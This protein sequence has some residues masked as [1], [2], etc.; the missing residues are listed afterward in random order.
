MKRSCDED[1]QF[2]KRA[3]DV[4]SL[5][6][7]RAATIRL[8][9]GGRCFDASPETLS[10]ATFFEPIITGRIGHAVD[11][12]NRVFIDR[13]GELFAVVLQFL[14]CCCRPSERVLQANREELL[15]E[16]D[17]Y[18]IEWLAQML[19]GEIS[20]FDLRAEDRALRRRE[21]EAKSDPP[22]AGL[23][24]DVH[25][26]QAA[27]R[28]RDELQLPI[29]FEGTTRQV[30]SGS[31]HDFYTRLDKWTGGLLEDLR[32]VPGLV[33][34]GGA[35]LSA[36]VEGTAGDLDIF[37]LG[38]E[39]TRQRLQGVFAA[40]QRNQARR[41]GI[42][43][44]LL[45]TR[46]RNAVTFFRVARSKL[47]EGAPPVQVITTFYNSTLEL[48]LGFD[49]DCCCFAFEADES[50]V[51]C[52]DR[53]LRALRYTANI[54]DTAHGGPSYCRRLEKYAKRGFAI[55]VPGFLAQRAS[56]NLSRSTY[57]MLRKYDL[58]LRVEAKA[59]YGTEMKIPVMVYGGLRAKGYETAR[60]NVSSVQRASEVRNMAR[61]VVLDQ[62]HIRDI[63]TPEIVFCERHSRV[64]ANDARVT[65]TCVPMCTGTKGEY[66]LLWGVGA[67][68]GGEPET[69][70]GEGDES[71]TP[72][73]RVYELL[74]H[75]FRHEMDACS[76]SQDGEDSWW[77]GGAM[78]RLASAMANVEGYAAVSVANDYQASRL[79]A[80]ESILFVY[81]FATCETGFDALRFVCDAGRKPLKPLGAEAFEET[82]G[83]PRELQFVPRRARE[84]WTQDWWAGVY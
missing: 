29:L 10:S 56:E 75:H 33:F 47:A 4:P 59:L 14:R 64:S 71:T 68:R 55:A 45:V 76:D 25:M 53:G 34:A 74:E 15:L 32:G 6:A 44:K 52:T 9:V 60:I 72:L 27:P 69:A 84:K 43:S 37:L 62:A 18:G 73:A 83:L 26:A 80:N 78:Q 39:G 5:L 67:E 35:V 24:L 17:F 38:V 66:Q 40:V 36:L 11:E 77:T 81:D 2:V 13:S 31:F 61:L 16:C 23:L 48:L 22:G 1:S 12:N 41:S 49:V 70:E 21:E 28:P 19:R 63:D 30:L 3:C 79:Q 20:P 46:S 54:V 50:R 42:K 7:S 65:G 8:N 82:F 58:L 57:F 51:L